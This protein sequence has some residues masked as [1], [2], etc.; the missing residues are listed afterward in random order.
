MRISTQYQYTK[1]I[2]QMQR[3]QST[4][5]QRSDQISTGKRL[6]KPSDDPVAAAQVV[7]LERELAQYNKFD[8]NINVTK[9]RLELEDSIL[10]DIYTAVD[11]VRQLSVQAGNTATLNDQDR[12]GIA[13]EMTQLT[14]YMAGLMNTQDSEGEYL[15]AGSKGSTQPY[16]AL[17]N[18]RYQYAGDDG[19]R[20]IQVG[21]DLYVA[22]NDSGQQLFEAV[23]RD[24][25]FT[26]TGNAIA[27][28]DNFLHN[29]TFSDTEA[30][31]RFEKSMQ[32][33]GHMALVVEEPT[34]GN[35]VYS[36]LDANGDPVQDDGGA[37]LMNIAVGNLATPET[38][39]LLG[40]RIELHAPVDMVNGNRIQIGAER[41]KIN[42]LEATVDLASVL[43][44][45]LTDGAEF[46]ETIAK[47]LDQL[48]QAQD[49]ILESR[50]QVGSRLKTL[51][52]ITESNLDFKLY[53]KSAL[54]TLVDVDAPTAISEFKLAQATLQAAQ[55]TFSQVSS[56]TLFDYIK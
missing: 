20:Q 45:P 14:E 9:R 2:D 31:T 22:S 17:G 5:A 35:Y 42:V 41:E 54:S 36:V 52:N 39:D 51:E 15:F 10:D 32:A 11:R 34:A 40:A 19:Q 7:K 1:S 33:A 28:G 30:E 25:E 4:I 50:A 3:T 29:V 55:A 46:K 37:A 16:Q 38:I 23:E 24:L 49:R 12:A 18:N 47:G 8:D 27:A 43:E 21:S 26:Y 53:T 56:L 48:Q 44:Q 13:K 6:L